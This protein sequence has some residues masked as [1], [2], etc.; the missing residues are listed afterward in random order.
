[1][2]LKTRVK[3]STVNNLSDARYGAGMG[4]AMMGF[5]LDQAH[6]HYLSP[7]QFQTITQWVQGVALVGE[8][9]TTNEAIIQQTLHQYSLHYLQL[10]DPV[11]LAPLRDQA[12]PIIIRIG[13]QGDE[14]LD[15]L[16]DRLEAYGSSVKYFLLEAVVNY[17]V[18][19]AKMQPMINHL[20]Q[21]FPILQGYGIT[22]EA[23]PDLL[24]TPVAGIALQGGTELKPGYKEFEELATILE[25]LATD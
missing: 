18:S 6:P 3:I 13:L 19:V 25:M 12:I 7:K 23:L 22:P 11:T 15:V 16:R 10:D 14:T 5:P 8:L 24:A 2:L 21:H 20:A 4:V 1:M 9:S 17:K